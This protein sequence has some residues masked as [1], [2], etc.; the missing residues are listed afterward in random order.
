MQSRYG[1]FQCGT[2]N[3][4]AIKS[5]ELA[6]NA[7]AQEAITGNV[8]TIPGAQNYVVG[9]ASC[10]VAQGEPNV[11]IDWKSGRDCCLCGDKN[12]IETLS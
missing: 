2:E 10:V 12:A 9:K 1:G 4:E 8:D 6:E 11:S 7:A 5:L 3:R